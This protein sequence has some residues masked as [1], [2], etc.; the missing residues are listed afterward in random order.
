VTGRVFPEGPALLCQAHGILYSLAHGTCVENLGANGDDAGTLQT[1]R[2]IRDG[3]KFIVP[4]LVQ[5]AHLR[6]DC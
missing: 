4:A 2:V 3:D 5:Q 6:E 1:F